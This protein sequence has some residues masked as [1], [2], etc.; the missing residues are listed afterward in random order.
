MRAGADRGRA[1]RHARPARRRPRRS[2]LSSRPMAARCS[3]TRSPT[4][5]CETQGKS[6]ACWSIRPSQRV[7]G[8]DG[9]RSMSASS[10][11][12][13][14]ICAPRSP[15]GRFRE[16][17]FHR[18]NVVPIRC[19]RWRNGA[20]TFPAGRSIS[21]SSIAHGH[22]P[23]AARSARTRSPCCRRMMAGQCPPAAQQCRAPADPGRRRRRTD[24]APTCC[25]RRSA[26]LARAVER[27]R[28]ASI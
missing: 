21:W 25:R 18:L 13:A 16:D 22:G 12:R 27:R 4:C 6:C 20:R 17:L 5:R 19:R 8:A 14:A 11:R 7:G 15:T 10:P 26:R 2:A 24:H 28:A 3:S 1:V 23:A 9:S